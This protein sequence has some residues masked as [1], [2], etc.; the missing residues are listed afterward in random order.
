MLKPAYPYCLSLSSSNRIMM[1]SI[2]KITSLT[3]NNDNKRREHPG[4]R[5]KSRKLCVCVCVHR[6]TSLYMKLTATQ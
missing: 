4:D 1:L 6:K 5:K 3:N 2:L